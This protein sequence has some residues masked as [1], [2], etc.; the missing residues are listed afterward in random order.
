MAETTIP[1][2]GADT[3]APQPTQPAATQAAPKETIILSP[4]A[5]E[6]VRP[7]TSRLG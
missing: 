7:F 4:S 2:G 3:L 5:G 6:T 1:A